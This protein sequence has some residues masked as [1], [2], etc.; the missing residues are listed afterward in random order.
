MLIYYITFKYVVK[1]A[2]LWMIVVFIYSKNENIC[3]K[4]VLSIINIINIFFI[5]KKLMNNDE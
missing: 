1:I 5:N 2:M 4:S 3:K